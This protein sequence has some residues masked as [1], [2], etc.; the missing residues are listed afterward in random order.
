MQNKKIILSLIFVL[1]L[2]GAGL[3][4]WYFS[5]DEPTRIAE[6]EPA[7]TAQIEEEPV[8]VIQEVFTFPENPAP[9]ELTTFCVE[10]QDEEGIDE[11]IFM[12]RDDLLQVN[13][14][15]QTEFLACVDAEF[16]EDGAWQVQ[17]KNTEGQIST[18]A[19]K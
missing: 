9:R 8:P 11:I 12:I 6:E 13:G 10:S 1:I 17:V 14:L 3:I 19:I 2:I 7:P 15:G 5:T 18:E 4:Y 16:P